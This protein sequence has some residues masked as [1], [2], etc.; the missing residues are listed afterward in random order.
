MT[1]TKGMRLRMREQGYV[2]TGEAA[3][4]LGVD[5][6]FITRALDKGKFKYVKI[7]YQKF[8]DR[9]ELEGVKM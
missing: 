2:T 8:I 9:K 1:L 5:F 4:I 3:V 6:N 7:G